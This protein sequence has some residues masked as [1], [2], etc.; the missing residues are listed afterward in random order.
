[1]EGSD[2][3]AGKVDRTL[4]CPQVPDLSE[5]GKPGAGGGIDSVNCSC[6]ALKRQSF[7]LEQGAVPNHSARRG[8]V[9]GR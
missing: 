9:S 1:M 2:V 4:S 8:L 7:R 5:S 6:R 3:R